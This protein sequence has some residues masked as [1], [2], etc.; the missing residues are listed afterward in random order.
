MF[1]V[2]QV[3]LFSTEKTIGKIKLKGCPTNCKNAASVPISGLFRTI[4]RRND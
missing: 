3:K 1:L 2:L 4:K